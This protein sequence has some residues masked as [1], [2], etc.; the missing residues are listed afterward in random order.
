MWSRYKRKSIRFN[1]YTHFSQ[2][3]IPYMLYDAYF[4]WKAMVSPARNGLT[5]LDPKL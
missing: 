3:Y 1:D 2:K 5:C 4:F